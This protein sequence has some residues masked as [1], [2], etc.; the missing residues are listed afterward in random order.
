MNLLKMKE[1]ACHAH[2][3]PIALAIIT[4]NTRSFWSIINY[5]VLSF[6]GLI[7]V[8]GFFWLL[9]TPP[10][11][12]LKWYNPLMIMMMDQ[13]DH[14]QW[15]K[16][17]CQ[18]VIDHYWTLL[19]SSLNSNSNWAWQIC[20]VLFKFRHQI[21]QIFFLSWFESSSASIFNDILNRKQLWN[22]I[23]FCCTE[24]MSLLI[25]QQHQM[26][27]IM[28][29]SVCKKIWWG[30]KLNLKKREQNERMRIFL[31][32]INQHHCWN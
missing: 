7:V 31:G 9:F 23:V 27:S 11:F 5:I 14:H 1:N 13:I 21:F 28:M 32:V 4:K 26:T 3:Q 12:Q 17:S 10:H 20:F 25:G 16:L 29:H 2:T 24:S 30:R 19:S 8:Q 6:I 15:M 22:I 18:M